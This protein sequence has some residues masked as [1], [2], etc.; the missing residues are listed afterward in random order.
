MTLTPTDL[1]A[2]KHLFDDRFEAIEKRFDSLELKIDRLSERLTTV[3]R[4]MKYIVKLYIE[5][6]PN[7]E[8]R[9]EKIEEHLKLPESP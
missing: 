5:D 7:H 6:I 2:I 3:E 8:G 9:I 1:E 4:Q